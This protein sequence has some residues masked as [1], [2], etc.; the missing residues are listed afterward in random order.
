[1]TVW[2]TFLLRT[3]FRYS[4]TARCHR[5][6]QLHI[7]YSTHRHGHLELKCRHQFHPH[8]SGRGNS[9]GMFSFDT[10][11]T[12]TCPDSPDPRLLRLV[13]SVD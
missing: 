4:A 10:F 3:F 9:D 8:R 6:F 5:G 2:Y 7:Q 12:P 11:T 1:M 13:P